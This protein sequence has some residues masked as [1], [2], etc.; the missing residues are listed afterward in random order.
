MR[1]QKVGRFLRKTFSLPLLSFT[2]KLDSF[3]TRPHGEHDGV[4]DV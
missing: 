1:G 4:H 2:S 3:F